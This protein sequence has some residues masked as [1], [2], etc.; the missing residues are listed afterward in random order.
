VIVEIDGWGK[1]GVE[2]DG[3]RHRL[4]A[5]RDRQRRLEDAGWRVVRWTSTDR[6]EVV[7]PRIQ[8]ALA[9]HS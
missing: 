7:I 1:Y 4:A 5:E 2:S 6:R 3:V 9:P 8:R